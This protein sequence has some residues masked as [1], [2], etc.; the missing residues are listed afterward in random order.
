MNTEKGFLF[1]YDWMPAF[2]ALSAQD[3]KKLFIAMCRYQFDG[4]LPSDLSNK[5]KAIG[6]WA[7]IGFV[8]GLV[9]QAVSMGFLMAL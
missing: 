9:L 8:V 2:E 3:F 4:T 6:K 5:A 7:L 1:F